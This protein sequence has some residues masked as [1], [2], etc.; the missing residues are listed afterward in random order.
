MQD[1]INTYNINNIY[2][3]VINK[4]GDTMEDVIQEYVKQE[5]RRAYIK[6]T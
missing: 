4:L 6:I 1:N 2:M 3:H 5:V